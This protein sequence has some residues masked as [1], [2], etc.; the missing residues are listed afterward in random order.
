MGFASFP[1]LTP[2]D[3]GSRVAVRGEEL[4]GLSA[5]GSHPDKKK[6]SPDS[7]PARG[8]SPTWSGTSAR[9]DLF[10]SAIGSPLGPPRGSIHH[11]SRPE[12]ALEAHQCA[13]ALDARQAGRYLCESA[14]GREACYGRWTPLVIDSCCPARFTGVE[15][16]AGWPTPPLA[17]PVGGSR[18]GSRT[19]F[20][21]PLQA[22]KPSPGPHKSRECL[23]LILLLRNRLK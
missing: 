16:G 9:L 11:G 3:V 8:G 17:A 15:S 7:H 6:A 21:V 1:L 2:K 12:E 22:P 13:Q 18:H 23:P 19:V 20:A 5:G 4:P 10:P 14:G